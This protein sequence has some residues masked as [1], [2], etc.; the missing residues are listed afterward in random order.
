MDPR[1][2]PPSVPTDST[3]KKPA[4][5]L[6]LGLAVA[7]GVTMLAIV[8]VLGWFGLRTYRAF[9]SRTAPTL[10]RP[11][12]EPGGAPQAAGTRLGPPFEHMTTDTRR[13]GDVPAGRVVCQGV[14]FECQGAIRL[15]GVRAAREGKRYPGAVVGVPVGL[16]GSQIHVLQATENWA[17]MPPRA[18]YGKILAHYENGETRSFYL[19]FRVHGLDWFGGPNTPNETVEDPNTRLGWFVRKPDGMYRRF[20]HTVF[21]NPLPAL[22]IRSVDVISTLE[23]A[24][25]WVFGLTVTKEPAAL[26]PEA[27]RDTVLA[28]RRLVTIHIVDPSD[29][30]VPTATLAWRVLGPRYQV[31]FPAFSADALGQVILDLPVSLAGAVSLHAT[32]PAGLTLTSPLERGTGGDSRSARPSSWVLPQAPARL[33]RQPPASSR[34][35]LPPATTP[36]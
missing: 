6:W 15:A 31:N 20:F 21:A 9:L 27:E 35:T 24:N 26:A 3:R 19:Q 23:S 2:N 33:P 12:R 11:G 28:R 7:A 32:G 10:H 8:V 34:W 17:G 5:F 29:R 25:L 22:E 4:L 36:V 1:Q 13:W 16:R 14:P 30:P 18:P